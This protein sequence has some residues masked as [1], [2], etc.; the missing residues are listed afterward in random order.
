[1]KEN[2]GR[3]AR[4]RLW[5]KISIVLVVF[6]FLIGGLYLLERVHDDGTGTD[7]W[8]I[9]HSLL[10]RLR[11]RKG[12]ANVDFSTS[13]GSEMEQVVAA[14]IH[15]IDIEVDKGEL[16]RSSSDSYDGIYGVFCKLNFAAHKQDPSSG[17]YK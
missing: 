12:G 11:R 5:N 2:N 15:L 8:R 3:A 17:T 10:K 9:R 7:K 1:M 6:V 4:R 13:G 16:R 14:A